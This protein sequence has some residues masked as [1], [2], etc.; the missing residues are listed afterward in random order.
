M[1]G[2][3]FYLNNQETQVESG[4][5]LTEVLDRTLDT[6]TLTLPF[7]QSKN[8]I[9]PMTPFRI[10]A[11]EQDVLIETLPF[12]VI[13][14]QVDLVGRNPN[15]YKHSITITQN[16]RELCLHPIRN[17]TFRQPLPL[18]TKVNFSCVNKWNKDTNEYTLK[19]LP[20]S[21][22][23]N[24]DTMAYAKRFSID[25]HTKIKSVRLYINAWTTSFNNS[26]G[27][28]YESQSIVGGEYFDRHSWDTIVLSLY[29]YTN[30]VR[31][32]TPITIHYT[33]MINDYRR[34][35]QY[36]ELPLS[37][38]TGADEYLL[39]AISEFTLGSQTNFVIDVKMLPLPLMARNPQGTAQY[40]NCYPLFTTFNCSLEFEQ[41]QFT[42][43]DVLDQINKTARVSRNGGYDVP[44]LYSL[45]HMSQDDEALLKSIVSPEF[46]FTGLDLFTAVSQVFEYI[47]AVPTLTYDKI[48]GFEYLNDGNKPQLTNLQK[49]NEELTF[50]ET[51]Y[52]SKQMV[53]YQSSRQSLA[54]FYPSN[55]GYRK[56]TLNSLGLRTSN[57][58][59]IALDDKIEYVDKLWCNLGTTQ[60]VLF[61]EVIPDL[62]SPT[63]GSQYNLIAPFGDEID[64]SYALFPKEIFSLLKQQGQEDSFPN[65]YNTL[66]YTKGENNI[67]L[68]DIVD[69]VGS[70]FK[71]SNCQYA[72]RCSVAAFFGFFAWSNDAPKCG[73]TTI[74][75]I[76]SLTNIDNIDTRKDIYWKVK[77]HSIYDGQAIVESRNTKYNGIS[78][79]SQTNASVDLTK[80]GISMVGL[81]NQL[82]NED[83][84]ITAPITD[85]AH[86]IKKGSWFL[87]ENG[88]KYVANIVRTTISSNIAKCKQ[89]IRFVRNFNAISNY[90]KVDKQKRFYEISQELC[91]KGYYNTVDYVYFSKDAHP[92]EYETTTALSNNALEV[93]ITGS[94]VWNNNNFENKKVSCAVMKV[95]EGNGYLN[96]GE[97]NKTTNSYYAVQLPL[98]T[99][100]FGNTLCFEVGFDSPISAGIRQGFAE[101]FFDGAIQS[102]VSGFATSYC[103]ENGYMD[104]CDIIY[105]YE[106]TSHL[107]DENYPLCNKGLDTTTNLINVENLAYY[108]RPNE[109]FHFNYQVCFLPRPNEEYYIGNKFTENNY[110]LTDTQFTPKNLWVGNEPYTI[111]DQKG[112]GTNVG[113]ANMSSVWEN[114]CLKIT[115]SIATSSNGYWALT[116]DDG[117]ILIASNEMMSGTSVVFYVFKRRSRL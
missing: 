45:E 18:K 74:G 51:E 82:A 22:G 101:V 53:Q 77:Y 12:V 49:A 84:T 111:S 10:E 31:T 98:H 93:M 92:D 65:Q 110:I 6:A 13:V 91:S 27:G 85:F 15:I 9:A 79:T 28:T 42:L 41:Y 32:R 106:E 69:M 70:H 73:T 19:S 36:V 61:V 5:T 59:V 62:T 44:L 97:V 71:T 58:Q 87:D 117:N 105:I 39:S 47:N 23:T 100:G 90:I 55:K 25:T 33:D 16:T 72:V 113:S 34:L 14:D 35:E 80:L 37:L 57:N 50:N 48:L 4:I 104:K 109:I 114:N 81:V 3:Y 26:D 24:A 78:M 94:L 86:R 107:E 7:G 40:T 83:L 63:I 52:T 30:G 76:T 8:P 21:A 43:Y 56:T 2:L 75:F 54:K 103:Y 88:N 99:Y 60:F 66:Y 89:E 95:R 1:D 108:K 46:T 20:I 64:M 68:G 116:D 112:K 38:F 115:I 102:M 29:K 17:S 67:W 11:W 96:L